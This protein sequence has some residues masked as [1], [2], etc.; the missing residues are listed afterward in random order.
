VTFPVQ[1]PQNIYV[2]NGVQTVFAYGFEIDFEP[3]ALTTPAV[4]V[5]MVV[6]GTPTVITPLVYNTDFTL[7]NIGGQAGGNLT[8]IGGNSPIANGAI[9]VIQAANDLT[10]QTTFPNQGFLPSDIEAALDYM[11]QLAQQ[12]NA[13]APDMAKVTTVAGLP[14]ANLAP[15]TRRFVTDST[16]TAS[17]Q[18][19]AI[20][21]GGGNN[22]VPVYSDAVNWRIG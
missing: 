15:F 13:K 18:F 12:I 8:T 2:G 16:V 22:T 3:D 7:T 11:T 4:N 17:G 19:G 9:L 20:V 6:P 10:Q 5:F 1:T 21:A 14:V